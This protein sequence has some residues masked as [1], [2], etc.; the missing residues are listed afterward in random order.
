LN[1]AQRYSFSAKQIRIQSKN[2]VMKV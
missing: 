2:D 1:R